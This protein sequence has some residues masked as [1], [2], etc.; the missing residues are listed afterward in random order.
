MAEVEG[1]GSVKRGLP[2]LLFLRCMLP[3]NL[4]CPPV[5]TLHV[6]RQYLSVFS[7]CCP[8]CLPRRLLE[9]PSLLCSP[10][11]LVS[12]VSPS[13]PIPPSILNYLSALSIPNCLPRCR[14]CNPSL[15]RPVPRFLPQSFLIS[16][17]SVIPLPS[18][19]SLCEAGLVAYEA[20]VRRRREVERDRDRGRELE[21]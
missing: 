12:A 8:S 21:T 5:N 1:K 10:F 9:F 17:Q 13:I 14:L 3:A 16:L 2:L 11:Y 4:F 7:V 20:P 18:P 15:L 6:L 19:T